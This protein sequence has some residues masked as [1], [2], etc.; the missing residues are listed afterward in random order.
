MV[1]FRFGMHLVMATLIAACGAGDVPATDGDS[2]D[3]SANARAATRLGAL[4]GAGDE[5]FP[6][7]TEPREFSFPA[8]HG[9]HPDYRNE[10]W[11]VTGN[12]AAD[13]GSR[14]GY[15]LTL[16]RF[17][18][19][20]SALRSDSGWRSRQVYVGHF[21]VSNLQ[22]DVFHAAERTAR[23]ALGLAGAAA[24]P[25][26]VWLEDWRLESAD[27]GST[28]APWHLV[29]G[30]GGYAV[31]LELRAKKPPV[32]NGR[33]GLSQKSS[34]EGNASYYYSMTRLQTSGIVVTPQAEFNVEGLSWLDREWSSSA[35]SAGQVGWDWFALQLAD[36]RDLMYYQ[37]RDAEGSPDPFSA[38]TLVNA[39]G[40]HV[41]LVRNDVV[42]SVL[43]YWENELGHRYPSGWRLDV[44]RENLS[45]IVTP[46][47]RAQELATVVRYW[48]GAVT[49]RDAR[50]PGDALVGRGYVELTGYSGPAVSD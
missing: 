7:V 28:G 39:D 3:E 37:I 16:F 43:D 42:L 11:Y 19:S 46:A 18:L 29:A 50:N 34:Q 14:F 4:L 10:W 27:E 8:D 9:P 21:A 20:P 44:P 26:R 49:V 38:G 13:D 48:E 12:L 2:N 1:D 15:E 40:T 6:T 23:G 35:L 24:E 5:G 36:G 22:D 30:D 33:D 32:A 45:L 47:F 25:F 41:R 17:A 31:N